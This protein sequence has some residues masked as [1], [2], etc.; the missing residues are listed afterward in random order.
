MEKVLIT[1]ITGF[2][3]SHLAD[4]LVGMSEI[5]LYGLKRYHLSR[6]DNVLHLYNRIIWLD[7]DLLDPKA[8]QNIIQ[9]NTYSKLSALTKLN[10]WKKIQ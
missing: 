10:H 8:I 4:L 5:E 6:E 9:D 2:V 3:G 1:G 7:C